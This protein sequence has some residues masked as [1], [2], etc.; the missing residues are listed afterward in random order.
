MRRGIAVFVWLIAVT[1]GVC[2]GQQPESIARIGF[3]KPKPGMARQFEEGRKRHN[4]WHRSQNDT[5]IWDTWEIVVGQRAGEYVTG[6]FNHKWADFDTF[7]DKLEKADTADIATNLEPYIESETPMLY[8][9]RADLSRPPAGNT[10]SPLSQVLHFRLKQGATQDFEQSVRRI[11]EAIRKTNW[12]VHF[13][14]YQLVNGGPEPQMT[15]VLPHDNWASFKE[16]EPSFPQMLENAFG[17]QGAEALL[18]SFGTTVESERDE[19][20]RYRPDLSYRPAGQTQA[21]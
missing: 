1:A 4:E 12:P 15:L 8:A 20:V 6:S 10:P 2:M 5:W 9:Y 3:F 16:P 7:A 21:Q 18:R 19:V 17:K 11:N 14:W 13:M